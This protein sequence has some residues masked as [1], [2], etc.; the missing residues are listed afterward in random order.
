VSAA[1]ATIEYLLANRTELYP[2]LEQL[3]QM[4][5]TGL[6]EIFAAHGVLACIARQGSA[7]TFYLMPETPVDF[8]DIMLQHDFARD[9]Q[10]RRALNTLGVFFVPVTTKQCSI[11]AAHTREDIEF[12]LTQCDRAVSRIWEH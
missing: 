6:R 3:G 9:L 2:R 1:I 8:H 11:S 7:F 12:T 4:M 10:L 5:E